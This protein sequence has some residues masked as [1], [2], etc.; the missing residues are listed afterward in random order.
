MSAPLWTLPRWP[1]RCAPRSRA[2]R[3]RRS[4]ACP[5]TAAAIAPGEAYFAIKGDVHDGHDF[6]DGRVEGRRRAG[7]GR[8]ARSA[9]NSR[10]TRR[11]WWSTMCWPALVELAHAARARLKG[12]MIAVTGSVGKTSTKE[13]LRR[14]LGAQGET[15]ASA[16]SFNNHWGV[17]LSLARCPADARFAIAEIGMNHAGEI[18]TLVEDGAAA[19]RHHHHGRAGASGVLRRHRGDRRRQGGNLRRHRARRRR[20]AEP[21]QCAIRAVDGAGQKTRRLAH[22]LVR[23]RHEIR[24]AAARSVAARDIVSGACRVFWGR[25][26]PTSSACPAATWR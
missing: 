2:R 10:P 22:R 13:A 8:S 25:T 6:V 11:F 26:S 12:Q 17:P 14:V 15:H 5:S 9:T 4:A 21:R 16:A 19:C 23:R 7:G 20:G 1:R 18:D 3:R 24:R